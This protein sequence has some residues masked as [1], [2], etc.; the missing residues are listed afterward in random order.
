LIVEEA[1]GRSSDFRAERF[2]A[3]ADQTLASNGLIHE[4]MLAV[5]GSL[6]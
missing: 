4:E 5:L 2:D 3:F 1:G 6:L